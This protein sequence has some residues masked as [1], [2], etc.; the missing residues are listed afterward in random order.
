MFNMAIKFNPREP[1]FYFNMANVLLTQKRFE[2][3]QLQLD[4]AVQRDPTN[5]KFWHAKG[6]TYE[7]AADFAENE[8]EE[9]E[10][11]NLAI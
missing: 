3:A 5:P 1:I 8:T 4:K 9:R 7:T 2:D 11:I 10:M 6:L